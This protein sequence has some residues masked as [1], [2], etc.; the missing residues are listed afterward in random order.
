MTDF[1]SQCDGGMPTCSTCTAVYQTSCF[2]DVD[3][4]H[5]RKAALKQDIEALKGRNDAL[6]IIVASIRSST[7]AEIAE[8]V[9]QIRADED[10]DSIAKPLKK[11]VM[12]PKRSG[13]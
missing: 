9:Q 13:A 12:L 7:D 2:Y 10:L 3:S 6:G 1:I 11:F 5:R 8:I 4:D